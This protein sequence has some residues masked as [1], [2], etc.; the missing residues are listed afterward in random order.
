L[1]GFFVNMLVMRTDMSGNPSFRELLERVKQMTLAAYQHQDLPFEQIIEML[2]PERTFSRTPL[3]QVEFTLQNAPLEPLE[4]RGLRFAPLN[5]PLK[6]SETDFNL[7]MSESGDA[8][9][10]EVVYSTD[11]FDAGTIERMADHFQILLQGIVAEPERRILELALTT[12]TEAQALLARWNGGA[13]RIVSENS[14]ST[15]QTVTD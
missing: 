3:Y 10:G 2:Q 14:R 15:F 11:L 7:M 1:I 6:S 5:V 4:T 12:N 8:L 13:T 9:V